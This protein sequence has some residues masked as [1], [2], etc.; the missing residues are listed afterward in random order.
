MKPNKILSPI[1]KYGIPLAISVGLCYNLF[2]KVDFST[3]VGEL[4]S[5]NYVWIGVALIV[6]IFSHVFRAMRW[7][8][9]LDALSI[10]VPLMPLVWS[11]F[12]TYAVNLILPRLGELWRSGYIA[13]RQDSPFTTVF[14]SMVADRLADTL[15]VLLLLVFTFFVS[16]DAFT[17]FAEKYPESYQGIVGVLHSPWLWACCVA[18][19]LGLTLL[20]AARTENRVVLKLRQWLKNLWQGFAV[21]VTMPGKDR[22]LLYTVAIWSC[23][24]IQL[25][26]AFFA[27]SFTE[28]LSLTAALVAFVLSSISMGIPSNGGLGPWHLAIIFALGLYGVGYDQAAAFSMIV[29]GSQNLLI[30]LLGLYSFASI[31]LDNRKEKKQVQTTQTQNR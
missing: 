30:I 27:F 29:W 9:Q 1:V 4:H 13:K 19:V 23:Y 10:R 21:V 26:L 16:S 20:F 18:G 25:Y 5:C 24:F 12:G 3:I 2:N 7:R 6:A 11:I 14:G 15:T 31:A 28:N 8:I 17:G 22:W